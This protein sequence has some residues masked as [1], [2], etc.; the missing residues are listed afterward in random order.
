MWRSQL[1]PDQIS[2]YAAI[3][4]CEKYPAVEAGNLFAAGDAALPFGARRDRP[5][6]P[7][8]ELELD[9]F[10][11]NA[12]SSACERAAVGKPAGGRWKN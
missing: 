6:V 12:V 10:R 11:Y 3:V 9:T 8:W 1:E 2:Y 5:A 4:S 7:G